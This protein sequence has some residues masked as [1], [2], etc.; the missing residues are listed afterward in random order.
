MK[1][2]ARA[3]FI[4]RTKPNARRH[5]RSPHPP[6][7]RRS[8]RGCRRAPGPLRHHGAAGVRGR[9]VPGPAG[10]RRGRPGRPGSVHPHGPDGRGRLR[11]GRAPRHRLAPA[12][13]VRDRHLHD[14][15]HVPAPGLPRW[16]RRHHRRRHPVDDGG[17]RHPAHRDASRGPGRERRPLPR[18]PAVGQ[19]AREGQDDGS[20]LPEPGGRP[21]RAA[22]LGRRRCARAADRRRPGRSRW[23]RL[24]A[25]ADRRRPR[26][27]GS[28]LPP[29]PPLARRLQRARPTRWTGRGRSAASDGRSS[30]A[31]SPSSA[32]ATP[33]PSTPTRPGASRCCSSAGSPSASPSPPTARS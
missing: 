15:R 10:V 6:P 4:E 5:R 12:P 14:R 30:Q 19:P 11:P 21:G 3:S 9:G 2:L 7:H 1:I 24:H 32:A 26:H 13:R 28:G 8:A 29:R 20:P 31:S 25:H 18:R 17:R 23:P 33:S 27:L 22:V 16:R